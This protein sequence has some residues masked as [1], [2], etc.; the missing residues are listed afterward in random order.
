MNEWAVK[1]LKFIFC[2]SCDFDLN[3]RKLEGEEKWS[4]V[5]VFASLVRSFDW[6][7][8]GIA[9]LN[10][11][12]EALFDIFRRKEAQQRARWFHFDSLH[13]FRVFAFFHFI[14]FGSLSLSVFLRNSHA[15]AFAFA[16]HSKSAHIF[17]LLCVVIEF[18]LFSCSL[19]LSLHAHATTIAGFC[20]VANLFLFVDFSK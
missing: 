20:A 1:I 15:S 16:L 12:N 2:S 9:T 3:R 13:C 14:R 18:T 6:R 19:L 8:Y 10:A 7:S 11:R 17:I 5:I 4:N